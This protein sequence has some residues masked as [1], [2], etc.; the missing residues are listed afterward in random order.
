M[1]AFDVH[2]RGKEVYTNEVEYRTEKLH[3]KI[4]NALY[5]ILVSF[6]QV[7][8]ISTIQCVKKCPKWTYAPSYAHYPQK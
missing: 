7:Y 6:P 8:K 1:S 2:R 5:D 4:G 3:K